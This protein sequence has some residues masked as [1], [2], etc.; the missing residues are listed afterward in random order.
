MVNAQDKMLQDALA[1]MTREDK[2]MTRDRESIAPT[3]TRRT[4]IVHAPETGYRVDIAGQVFDVEAR[5][6][7]WAVLSVLLDPETPATMGGYV[8]MW[9]F[10]VTDSTGMTL[11][12]DD[13]LMRDLLHKARIDHKDEQHRARQS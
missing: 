4:E 1:T 5:D 7:G 13:R 3:Y 6:F 10:T 2:A 9:R 12:G 8:F 11:R